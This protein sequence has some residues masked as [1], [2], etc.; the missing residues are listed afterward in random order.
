MECESGNLGVV[1]DSLSTRERLSTRSFH[2]S[3]FGWLY[4]FEDGV[5][6]RV[7]LGRCSRLRAGRCEVSEDLVVGEDGGLGFKNLHWK[8]GKK[9][10]GWVTM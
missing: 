9:G 10:M 8:C 7:F 5:D 2:G 1:R 6:V 3:N 4:F